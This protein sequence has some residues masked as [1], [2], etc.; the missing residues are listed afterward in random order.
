MIADL[1]RNRASTY[2]SSNSNDH[3]ILSPRRPSVKRTTT[4]ENAVSYDLKQ[5]ANK[6]AAAMIKNDEPDYIHYQK[7]RKN[8]VDSSDTAAASVISTRSR[9]K[10]VCYNI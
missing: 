9:A 4:N 6:P 2:P 5:I 8:S 7:R 1:Y 10:Q 3:P